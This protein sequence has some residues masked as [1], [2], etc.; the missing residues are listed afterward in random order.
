MSVIVG[1]KHKHYL[2]TSVL[3][4]L[5]T[6]FIIYIFLNHLHLVYFALIGTSKKTGPAM[7]EGQ[8]MLVIE[9][10]SLLIYARKL[11]T[12]LSST[13]VENFKT[14][15]MEMELKKDDHLILHHYDQEALLKAPP[16][17]E[18]YPM[19]LSS[20]IHDSTILGR[21]YTKTQ[22]SWLRQA[23]KG[24][25]RNIEIQCGW[26]LRNTDLKIRKEV[27]KDMDKRHKY[28]I[29]PLLFENIAW[30]CH[31]FAKVVQKLYQIDSPHF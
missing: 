18:L 9:T 6:K 3:T 26:M 5:I 2:N 23:Q 25:Q 8:K 12:A 24:I 4:N 15:L 7:F 21:R 28:E 17:P 13:T 1:Y 14:R 20:V 29:I 27:M 19:I 16:S 10:P 22:T 30:L 31:E 11:D